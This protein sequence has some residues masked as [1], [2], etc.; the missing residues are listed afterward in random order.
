MQDPSWGAW[1]GGVAL[2]SA[3]AGYAAL[4]FRFRKFSQR[5]DAGGF[6][7]GS[8]EFRASQA[9][10]NE[11]I[12]SSQRMEH[13][14]AGATRE[15]HRRRYEEEYSSQT[16]GSRGG[17]RMRDRVSTPRHQW[18]LHELG[19]GMSPTLAEAKD[20]YHR[21]AREYHPDGGG[22]KADAEAFKRISQAWCEVQKHCHDAR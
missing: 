17:E 7:S 11:W 1:L 22:P 12:R 4:A 19:L 14:A 5:P 10:S 15:Q 13:A 16:L 6:T 20:A 2:V 3:A 8:V 9:F 21:R 18:A